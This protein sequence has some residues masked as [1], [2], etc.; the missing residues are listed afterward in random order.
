MSKHKRWTVTI[1]SYLKQMSRQ[2]LQE[3]AYALCHQSPPNHTAEPGGP[4]F[5]LRFPVA[6]GCHYLGHQ[7]GDLQA[8]ADT[9]N[10]CEGIANPAAIPDVVKSLA[11]IVGA[12]PKDGGMVRLDGDELASARAALAALNGGAA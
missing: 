11:T 9:L 2:G 8:I 12:M 4:D 5:S 1:T 7:K 10:A 6:V 3:S